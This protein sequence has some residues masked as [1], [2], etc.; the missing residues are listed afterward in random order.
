MLLGRAGTGDGPRHSPSGGV[1]VFVALIALVQFICMVYMAFA[2]IDGAHLIET[3]GAQRMRTQRIAYL[4]LAAQTGHASSDWHTEMDSTVNEFL[5]LPRTLRGDLVAMPLDASTDTAVVRA[6]LSYA[7]AARSLEINPQDKA[8]LRYIAA[9]RRPL[10]YAIDS[11]VKHEVQVAQIRAEQLVAG[12]SVGLACMVAIMALAWKRILSPYE[13]LTAELI[14]R[15]NRT[16]GRLRSLLSTNSDGS[17]ATDAKHI[18]LALELVL[19][20][21]NMQFSYVGKFE[22]E[23]I[24]IEHVVGES[25]VNVDDV[26]NLSETY[27]QKGIPFGKVLTVDDLGNVNAT[28]GVRRYPG[29]HAYIAAPLFIEGKEYGAIGFLSKNVVE[30]NESDRDFIQLVAILVSSALERR[31]QRKTLDQLAFYDTLTGLSNRTKLMQ[32]LRSAIGLGC[33][34][35]RPFALHFIDLDGFKA[36]NDT[37]GH[38]VGDLV[39]QEAAN[40]LTA[41]ARNFDI[42]ARLGGDEFVVLQAEVHGP[43][44]AE[45]LGHRLLSV[46]SKAYAI[47]DQTLTVS[48]SIGIALFPEHGDDASKLLH[49]ADIALYTAKAKGKNRIEIA[50]A[51]GVEHA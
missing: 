20:A 40:R 5:T 31:A 8:G 18:D 37:L 44:E 45:A 7:R 30:F 17:V 35:K 10:L 50:G 46:L 41:A 38:G 16:N 14:V 24:R 33:R 2:Q 28:E 42:A 32:D 47:G 25:L 26:V 12:L 15:L 36:I 21:F 51:T 9:N 43:S 11:Y 6:M 39:L 13:R 27:V 22:G 29:W 23:A 49:S 3:G 4:A 34:H 1:L 48:A 19:K